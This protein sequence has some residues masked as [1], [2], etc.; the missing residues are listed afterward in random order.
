MFM[1]I[2]NKKVEEKINTVILVVAFI[3]FF[4]VSYLLQNNC[5]H[6]ESEQ[7]KDTQH[8]RTANQRSH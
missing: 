4:T 7:H 1:S 2:K 6:Y 3:I 5:K 8:G